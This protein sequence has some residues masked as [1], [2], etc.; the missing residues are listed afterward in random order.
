MIKNKTHPKKIPQLSSQDMKRLEEAFLGSPIKEEKK[1]F[2]RKKHLLIFFLVI[3]F[4]LGIT[5][6]AFLQKYNILFIPKIRLS[7]KNLLSTSLLNDITILGDQEK[8]RF[9]Q[10][11]LYI[12]LLPQA[13][14]G[15]SLNMKSPLNLEHNAIKVV[16]QLA[17]DPTLAQHLNIKAIARDE[18]YFSNSVSPLK[19]NA[20]VTTPDAH[21]E[22]LSFY[23]DFSGQNLLSTNLTRINHL[24]FYFFNAN[25]DPVS[26]L[27]KSLE[28]V[29]KKEGK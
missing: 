29:S 4:A 24:R 3:A 13:S 8:V 14:Q 22:S 28:L 6:V 15:F 1:S 26:M 27:I 11:I 2:R 5:G 17:G 10:G 7:E 23:L 25:N 16:F 18:K 20:E 9:S 21:Q 12:A 19:E